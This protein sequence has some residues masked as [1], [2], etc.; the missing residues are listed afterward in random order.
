MAK[1]RKRPLSDWNIFVKKVRSENPGKSFKEVLIMAAALKKK[2]Q[3][4]TSGKM[5]KTGKKGKGKTKKH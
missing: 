4:N 2:G 5:N 3:M 1:T